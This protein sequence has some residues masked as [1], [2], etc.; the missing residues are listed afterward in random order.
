MPG[1]L[2]ITK[3]AESQR[4]LRNENIW[5]L[6]SKTYET[7]LEH[8]PKSIP[9]RTEYFRWAVNAKKYCVSREQ[10]NYSAISGTDL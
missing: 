4:H 1:R 6:I 8:Y 3:M 7:F 5:E 10:L 9:F 2:L